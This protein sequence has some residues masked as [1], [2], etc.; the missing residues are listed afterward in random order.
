MDKD[1][2][3]QKKNQ[4]DDEAILKEAEFHTYVEKE[5]DTIDEAREDKENWINEQRKKVGTYHILDT[6]DF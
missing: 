3:Q 6:N 2:E 4:A 1:K 5:L